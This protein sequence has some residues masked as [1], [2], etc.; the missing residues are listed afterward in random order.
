MKFQEQLCEEILGW[1]GRMI[2]GSKSGY[3]KAYPDNFPIF[4]ANIIT[5]SGGKVWYGDVDIKLDQD[6]LRKIAEQLPEPIYILSEHDARF[7]NED[8]P[9]EFYKS[10]AMVI[11]NGKEI[12]LGP[13][14]EHSY[15]Q[16]K[17]EKL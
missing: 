17:F 7:E 11:V 3:M 6:N 9:F 2:Y 13:K 4:N 8:K 14:A 12:S 5:E 10:R 16:E 15:Y 1:P